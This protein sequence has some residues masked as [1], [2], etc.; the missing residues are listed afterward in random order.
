VAARARLFADNYWR[1]RLG[2]GTGCGDAAPNTGVNAEIRALSLAAPRY[3]GNSEH[4]RPHGLLQRAVISLWGP[5]IK[6]RQFEWDLAAMPVG[7]VI[8]ADVPFDVRGL[9]H[10]RRSPRNSYEARFFKTVPVQ[11]TEIKVAQKFNRLHLLHGLHWSEVDGTVVAS[12]ILHFTDGSTHETQ[13]VYG[14]D[15]RDWYS[16]A[17]FDQSTENAVVAW[18][19]SNAS[20]D[21]MGG[22]IR[23]YKT[24]F[25][26]PTPNLKVSSIDWISKVT[27]CAPF[28]IAITVQ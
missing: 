17:D 25:D 9:I 2:G 11:V 18:S 23:I 8:L 7:T 27:R 19:G 4:D 21:E 6:T 1:G 16:L 26:N 12:L 28:I 24:T 20:I 14:R 22:Q 15:V 10:L 13:V 3:E 5:V